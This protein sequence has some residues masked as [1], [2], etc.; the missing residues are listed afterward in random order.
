MNLL[1]L[2]MI[3]AVSTGLA[4]FLVAA[5][6]ILLKVI[7]TREPRAAQRGDWF[8]RRMEMYER[9]DRKN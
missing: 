1:A 7:Q 8:E 2:I 6:L 3:T 5:F 9:D 4:F